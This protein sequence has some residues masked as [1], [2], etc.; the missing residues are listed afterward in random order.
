M[1]VCVHSPNRRLYFDTSRVIDAEEPVDAPSGRKPAGWPDECAG[2]VRLDAEGGP[3][4][5][6][7]T[8]AEWA[9][10]RLA[11]NLDTATDLNR[12]A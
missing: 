4:A 5:V 7:F 12:P 1:L 11:L 10:V 2:C 9:G 8:P 3:V 6:G